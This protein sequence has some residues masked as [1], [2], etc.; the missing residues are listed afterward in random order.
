MPFGVMGGPSEFRHVTGECFYDLIAET[1][2][3]LFVDNGGMALDSFEEGMTKLKA[4]LDH[5]HREKMSLSPSK[6]KVF[7]TEAVFVGAQVG[8]QVV[9]PDSSKL[10]A[11]I[12]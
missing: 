10:M 1:V 8:P 2:L 3:E 7:M 4:L 9:S 6:L 12:N 5:V 11:I